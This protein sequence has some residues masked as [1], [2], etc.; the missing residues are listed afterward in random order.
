MTPASI[1]PHVNVILNAATLVLL[2]VGFILVRNGSKVGHRA[3]M[4]SAMGVSAI[5][6]TSYLIYHATSPIFLFRG[7]GAM[8]LFYYAIMVSHVILAAIVTPMVVLAASHSLRGRI[9]AHRRI[10][11]WTWPVW[12]YVSATGIVVYV[13]LYHLN[14]VST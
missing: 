1:L 4:L 5:F 8:K 11:R 9:E 7:E 2:V 12:I 14:P 6:L 13:L 3:V 10:A